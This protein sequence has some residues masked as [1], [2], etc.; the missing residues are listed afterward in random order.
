MALSRTEIVKRSEVKHGIKLKAF[1]LPLTVIAEIEQLSV[2]LN[3]PQNQ[4]IIKA[5]EQF[6]QSQK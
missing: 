4:L 3:I 5:I 2:Q 6:K 1:K